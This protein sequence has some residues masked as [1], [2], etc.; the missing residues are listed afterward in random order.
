MI[1][2]NS[3]FTGVNSADDLIV[4]YQQGVRYFPASN[5]S[6]LKLRGRVLR[7]AR[8]E[9]SNLECTDFREANLEGAV[10]AGVAANGADFH[11]ANLTNAYLGFGSFIG[12][13][14]SG[15]DLTGA[16]FHHADLWCANFT[17]ATL[18]ES[19]HD[20][21]AE[22]LRQAAY[23]DASK[24]MFAGLVL[25]ERQ[26]CW[27]TFLVRRLEFPRHVWDWAMREISHW[28]PYAH[29]LAEAQAELA[30][31]RATERKNKE[32]EK[33]SQRLIDLAKEPTAKLPPHKRT[34]PMKKVEL[35]A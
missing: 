33:K 35:L 34:R 5:L 22:V 16:L 10:L 14:F 12:A 29:A 27:R 17:G 26:W 20:V 13:D 11:D 7:H 31:E 6:Y 32:A 3:A 18:P 8:L 23:A 1:V 4:G 24:L 2:R 9:G 21:L 25:L 28:P 15:A 30:E 19:S